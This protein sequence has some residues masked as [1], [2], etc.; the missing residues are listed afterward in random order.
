M[1]V[2][3]RTQPGRPATHAPPSTPAMVHAWRA[4]MGLTQ[5]QASTLVGISRFR[6]CRLEKGT[7]AI[8]TPLSLLLWALEQYPTF[9]QEC[10]LWQSL[11]SP[12]A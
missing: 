2:P 6:W 1:T 8:D 9:R 3:Q 10:T 5:A 11:Q 4:R 12:V 7:L